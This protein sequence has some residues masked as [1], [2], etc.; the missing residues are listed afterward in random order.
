LQRGILEPTQMRGV[1]DVISQSPAGWIGA[2][3]YL[4][5]GS[6]IGG[7]VSGLFGCSGHEHRRTLRKCG[8]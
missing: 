7:F 1:R 5:D 2:A 8:W 4:G 3:V 6:S